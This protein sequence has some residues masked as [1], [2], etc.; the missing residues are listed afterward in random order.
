[1]KAARPMI[2]FYLSIGILFLQNIISLASF[3]LLS[4]DGGAW[5]IVLAVFGIV[6]FIYSVVLSLL[7]RQ[8]GV[9]PLHAALSTLVLALVLFMF[10]NFAS[11]FGQDG[12]IAH[13][14]LQLGVL[15]SDFTPYAMRVFFAFAPLITRSNKGSTVQT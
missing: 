9:R 13:I 14:N 4:V 6:D 12:V 7:I 3:A 11:L 1:M 10:N 15:H 5:P 2:L 8:H